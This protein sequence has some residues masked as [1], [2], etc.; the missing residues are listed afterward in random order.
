MGLRFIRGHLSD[1]TFSELNGTT[2]VRPWPFAMSWSLEHVYLVFFLGE[3]YFYSLS[4]QLAF[5]FD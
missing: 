2:Q 1:S 4:I 3:I 5:L